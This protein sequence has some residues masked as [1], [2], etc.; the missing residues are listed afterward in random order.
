MLLE[1]DKNSTWKQ[2]YLYACTWKVQIQ[3]ELAE[4]PEH[5]TP[6]YGPGLGYSTEGGC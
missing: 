2:F 4:G 6:H 5:S 1:I 3:P